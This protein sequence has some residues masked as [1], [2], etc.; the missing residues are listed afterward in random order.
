MLFEKLGNQNITW[1]QPWYQ[2]Y[3]GLTRKLK[4]ANDN[5]KEHYRT[6]TITQEEDEI[7]KR[8]WHK[9]MKVIR[10]LVTLI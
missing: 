1:E 5:K 4:D 10:E 8:N 9:L 6:D 3:T 7:I 2:V